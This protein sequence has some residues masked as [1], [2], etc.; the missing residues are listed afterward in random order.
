MPA[1]SRPS[2][3]ELLADSALHII[4][5]AGWESHMQSNLGHH[6]CS[7]VR[8]ELQFQSRPHPTRAGA[9]CEVALRLAESGHYRSPKPTD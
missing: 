7:L 9:V 4:E 5:R 3:D 8:H 1:T 2:E 6:T